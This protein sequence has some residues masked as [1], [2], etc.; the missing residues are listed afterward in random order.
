MKKLN[1]KDPKYCNGCQFLKINR[2]DY[3][4]AI[5]WKERIYKSLTSGR[6]NGRKYRPQRCIKEN[7]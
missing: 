5:Y 3:Y 7:G 2:K 6:I 1:L 4:C